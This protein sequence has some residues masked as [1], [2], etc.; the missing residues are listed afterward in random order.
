MQIPDHGPE[1]LDGEEV[2]EF[3]WEHFYDTITLKCDDEL[4]PTMVTFV[5][6]Y[7][8]SPPPYLCILRRSSTPPASLGSPSVGAPSPL[9]AAHAGDPGPAPGRGPPLRGTKSPGPERLRRCPTRWVRARRGRR[10]GREDTLWTTTPPPKRVL[11]LRPR[12]P[13]GSGGSVE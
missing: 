10:D 11:S 1:T 4:L 8:F 2:L 12:V 3:R 7:L 5:N 9:S 13:P 6:K